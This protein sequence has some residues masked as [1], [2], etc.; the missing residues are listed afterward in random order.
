MSRYACLLLTTAWVCSAYA[1]QWLGVQAPLA[2]APLEE[3]GLLA[4]SKQAITPDI[5]DF[6]EKLMRLTNVQGLS[7]AVV[8]LENNTAIPEFG[9][10]GNRTEDGDAVRADVRVSFP[11]NQCV[12]SSMTLSSDPIQHWIDL[13]GVSCERTR[14]PHGRLRERQECDYAPSRGHFFHLGHKSARTPPG[15]LGARPRVGH[16]E[17]EP[18]RHPDA[19]L[20]TH[21]VRTCVAR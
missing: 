17:G 18:S 15:R 21:E 16:G 8:R 1:Q 14:H 20:G 12:S 11:R 13:K 4:G 19:R 5:K 3:A 6:A 10:W 2:E 7:L 9:I